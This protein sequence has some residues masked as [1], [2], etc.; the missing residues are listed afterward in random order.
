MQALTDV[1]TQRYFDLRDS[2][3]WA[4]RAPRSMVGS[5]LADASPLTSLTW[6]ISLPNPPLDHQLRVHINGELSFP[7]LRLLHV[8]AP[9]HATLCFEARPKQFF[10]VPAGGFAQGAPT[11]R[12]LHVSGDCS[13]RLQRQ[14]LPRGLTCL[15]L[16]IREAEQVWLNAPLCAA[17]K[18]RALRLPSPLGG[19]VAPGG[20]QRLRALTRLDL[21]SSYEAHGYGAPSSGFWLLPLEGLS[22]LTSLRAL[23]L[24]C[25][26]L[27]A[28]GS[29]S[30]LLPLTC[31]T[32]VVLRGL[33]QLREHS[34][35]WL[36]WLAQLPGLRRL[37]VEPATRV[38]LPLPAHTTSLS[39]R[40]ASCC[41]PCLLVR[42]KRNLAPVHVHAAAY[43]GLALLLAAQQHCTCRP[44][45]TQNSYK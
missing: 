27:P 16:D 29:W 44:W 14:C 2:C 19:A 40:G 20:L 8:H 43:L 35:A 5:V 34:A 4:L 45:Q 13:V 21:T 28:R 24:E 1:S 15:Q 9:A 26:L 33:L 3:I 42:R 12:A 22:P 30:Q 31:L 23:S 18:L 10:G 6:S 7:R 25:G 36:P 39:G 37:T 32:S 11:L 38:S 17:A 41:C